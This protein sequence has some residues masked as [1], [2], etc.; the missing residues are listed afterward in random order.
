MKFKRRSEMEQMG[1]FKVKIRSTKPFPRVV[2]ISPSSWR[3]LENLKFPT[4]QVPIK[5]YTR[6]GRIEIFNPHQ[7]ISVESLQEIRFNEKQRI[8]EGNSNRS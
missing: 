8:D 5:T 6:W 4:F 2:F 1:Y 7:I 3:D